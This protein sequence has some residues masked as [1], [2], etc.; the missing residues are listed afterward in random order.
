[1]NSAPCAISSQSCFCQDQTC[2]G[3]DNGC[4]ALPEAVCEWAMAKSLSSPCCT[5]I[6]GMPGICSFFFSCFVFCECLYSAGICICW[7]DD[8]PCDSIESNETEKSNKT[9][10]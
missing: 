9:S 4:Q 8:C 6:P 2:I 3:C 7:S 1:M 10:L 5:F